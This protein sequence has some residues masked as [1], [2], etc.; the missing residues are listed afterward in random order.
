M[1][2]SLARWQAILLGVVV[3]AAVA[4]GGF[5]LAR[6]AAKQ[7]LWAESLEIRVT[8]PEVHDISPGTPVRIRG[9][10][11][12]QVVAIELP[13]SADPSA[14]V[15]LRLKVDAR[16]AD[17]LFADAAARIQSTGLLGA[18]VIAIA[19]G[20][21]TAGPLASG[22]IVGTSPRDLGD[23][24]AKLHDTAVEAEL[25]LRDIRQSNGTLAKLLKD[26]DLYRDLKDLAADSRGFVKRADGAVNAVEAELPHIRGFVRDG[27]DTLRSIKS[28]TDAFQRMPVIRSYVENS[29]ALLVRP[30]HQRERLM[31]RTED[32]FE[33]GTSVLNETGLKH[34]TFVAARLLEVRGPGSDIVAAVFCD[35]AARD[36][37]PESALELSR[38]QSEAIVEF[39]RGHGVHK[40]SFWKSSLKVTPLGMGMNPSPVVDMSP[41]TASRVE[42]LMFTPN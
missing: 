31:F 2:Q 23:A 32:I 4:L 21:P 12:G 41:P 14:A 3:L 26:D 22:R 30:G 18:K 34:M 28:G 6:I 10:D 33:P 5:G 25:L 11:A 16:Y 19:P 35:P 39:L 36:Q 8:F 29:T 20:T 27:Q 7:G 1:S 15:T 17:R 42:V 38:R 37:T 9:V 13:D 24:A 40:T